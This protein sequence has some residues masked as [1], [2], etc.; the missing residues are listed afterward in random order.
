MRKGRLLF[1]IFLMAVAAFSIY[2]A[3]GWTFKTGF[4]PLAVSVPLLILATV[5]LLQ[6][7]FG[8]EDSAAGAAVDL[9]FAS[10]VPAE[11]ARRRVLTTFGW[12]VG[13]ILF[14]YLIGFPLTVPLFVLGYLKFQSE[15]SWR[16]SVTI[17]AITWGFFYLLF[18]RLVHLQFETGA[19]QTWLGL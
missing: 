1:C 17:T 7:I 3:S 2:S 13:F 11:L 18:E 6:E 14:V 10:D 12:I 8:K 15:V 16:H 19:V 4:F 9:D 5:Q